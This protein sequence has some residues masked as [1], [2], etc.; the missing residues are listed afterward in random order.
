MRIFLLIAL[1]C[2]ILGLVCLIG[3]ATTGVF[4]TATWP[5]WAL[6]GFISW[7][8]DTLVGGYPFAHRAPPA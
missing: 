5:D 3:S 6:G 2:F 7:A 4:S 8:L 1:V